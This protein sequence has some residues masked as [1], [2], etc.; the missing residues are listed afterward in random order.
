[1]FRLQRISGLAVDAKNDWIFYTDGLRKA[2]SKLTL[3]T[4]AR[5]TVISSGLER[6]HAIAV[7]TADRVIFWSNVGSEPKIERARYDGSDRKTLINKDITFV[8]AMVLDVSND[9]LYWVDP[10]LR[11]VVGCDME[12]KG[13]N[14]LLTVSSQRT[15]YGL[16]LFNNSLYIT[17]RGPNVEN[18]NAS[19]L[20]RVD[21][22]NK[23]R[24][25]LNSTSFPGLRLNGIHVY[26]GE[27]TTELT[28]PPP[29][30]PKG[31]GNSALR[32]AWSWTALFIT[33]IIVTIITIC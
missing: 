18:A 19:A 5:T 11:A 8:N 29:T 1:M 20:I 6:P 12:G 28:T 32:T 30:D 25:K 9:R 15:L 13:R 31:C 10:V 2:V 24:A 26:A 14:T 7:N 4:L 27:L 23:G 33:V 16:A 3:S 21:L 22:E 17:D